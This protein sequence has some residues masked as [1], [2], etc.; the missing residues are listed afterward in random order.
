MLVEY[1]N[2]VNLE[3][4]SWEV[5][6]PAEDSEITS[7]IRDVFSMV[8]SVVNREISTAEKVDWAFFVGGNDE[9]NEAQNREGKQP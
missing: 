2:A 1:H 5:Y 8:F 7:A 4:D 9:E 3:N 6:N